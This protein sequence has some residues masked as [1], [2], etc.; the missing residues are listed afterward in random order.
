MKFMVLTELYMIEKVANQKAMGFV[1]TKT[2]KLPRAL[3]EISMI[4]I[5]MGGH[6]ELAM[7]LVKPVMLKRVSNRVTEF[8]LPCAVNSLKPWS[9]ESSKMVQE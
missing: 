3:C 1:N 8:T 9:S 4:M 5:S 6:Y 7:Q 2:Q